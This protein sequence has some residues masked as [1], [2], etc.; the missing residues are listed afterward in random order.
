MFSE[1]LGRQDSSREDAARE[2][3]AEAEAG[4]GKVPRVAPPNEVSE[5]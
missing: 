4:R 5:A 1:A 3:V 2:L